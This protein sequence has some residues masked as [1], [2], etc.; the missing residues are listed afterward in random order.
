MKNLLKI[1]SVLLYVTIFL[2]LFG[3]ATTKV[4]NVTPLNLYGKPLIQ[5]Y[6]DPIFDEFKY[7]TFTVIPS[8]LISDK[9]QIKNQ[10]GGEILEKQML[11]S[12]RNFFEVKGYKFVELDKSPDFLVTIDGSAPYK[13]SY[14]PPQ[15]VMLPYWVPGQTITTQNRTSGSFDLYTYNNYGWG[16]YGGTSASTTYIP[17]YMTTI[18]YTRPGYTVG[19]YYPTISI[20]MF[21][22]ES[23]M[24]IWNGVGV[25]TS[26][27]P[28]FRVSSQ[29]LMSELL[30]KN[31]PTCQYSEQN[32]PPIRGGI[33]IFYQILTNDGNNYFPTV[34]SVMPKFPA[35]KA[36]VKQFDMILAIDGVPTQNKPLLEIR[37]LL[38]GD[39]GTKVSLTLWR[40]DKRVDL[41][42]I[43][44][45]RP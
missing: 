9:S 23:L 43:R 34:V 31:F 30:L 12:L 22:G 40:V 24:N 7:K 26:R 15:T 44:M 42:L 4:T 39:A 32:Y 18:P 13:E 35:E 33:G 3:C 10:P 20:G 8:S 14:I 17:G 25:G 41:Q 11:F 28:D 2:M 19:Y 27:N 45:Q 29:M 38:N 5:T 6:K 21:D 37:N 1:F 16:T 36:G